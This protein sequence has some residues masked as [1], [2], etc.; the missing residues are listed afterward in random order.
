MKSSASK[1]FLGP[2]LERA[3]ALDR[4]RKVDELQRAFM[5]WLAVILCTAIGAAIGKVTQD[6]STAAWIG[7]LI[8]AVASF[9]L[10]H[11]GAF[12]F[13]DV[14]RYLKN[15]SGV[16]D[17]I[18]IVNGEVAFKSWGTAEWSR[19]PILKSDAEYLASAAGIRVSEVEI[20]GQVFHSLQCK[21]SGAVARTVHINAVLAYS[22]ELD[23]LE[24]FVEQGT[25]NF[26]EAV[27]WIEKLVS[28]TSSSCPEP[29]ASGSELS[30]YQ[31][32]LE[33]ITESQG[34]NGVIVTAATPFVI[35][36]L[37]VTEI[38]ES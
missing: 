6:T 25:S 19:V 26:G 28:Q 14:R 20:G 34:A 9:L 12:P 27:A 23:P 17:A 2:M 29:G 10:M 4:D 3:I 8:G 15:C 37:F 16:V 24:I 13:V 35:R 31:Q 33:A 32:D 22:D 5:F 36:R 18:A 30:A 38:T 11:F 1:L 7:A 21:T